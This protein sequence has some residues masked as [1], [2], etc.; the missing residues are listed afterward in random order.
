MIV[1]C[2][3]R[4]AKG[5]WIAVTKKPLPIG[6]EFFDVLISKNLYYVDKTLFIKEILDSGSAVTLITRPRRFVKTLNMSTLECFFD[7]TKDNAQNGNRAMA[8]RIA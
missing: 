7:I 3:A 1:C 8:A 2:K 6:Q 4:I 5:G